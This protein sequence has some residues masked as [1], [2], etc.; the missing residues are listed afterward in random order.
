[1]ALRVD[2]RSRL[3][4]PRSQGPR[5]TCLAF[6]VSAVHESVLFDSH[7]IVDV[8]EEYLY[9]A[10]KQRDTPGTGTTFPAMRDGLSSKGQPLE[11]AWPYDEARNDQDPGYQPPPAA[12][13]VAPR[14]S[15]TLA[16]IPANPASVR[17]QLDTGRA[18]VL[19]MPTWPAFDTPV[20]GRLAVPG[21]AELDG[22]YHAVA[23]IGY[24]QLSAEML[25]R[26]SWGEGWGYK[27]AAWLGL[28]FLDVHLC[29]TWVID[30]A[31]PVPPAQ[32]VAR[33]ARRYRRGPG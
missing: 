14:W 24:D 13:A 32:A 33:S 18:V 29:E 8:C 28:S 3:G 26:N 30:P 20:A 6:A 23:I 2:L 15:P 22:A 31:L 12:H 1:M 27:G 10:A 16:A 25:L 4:P 17:G 9:W 7:D 21:K 19:G 5:A 11:E